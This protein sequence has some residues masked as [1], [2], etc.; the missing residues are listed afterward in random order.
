MRE[1]SLYLAR[2]GENRTRYAHANSTN[3]TACVCVRDDDT[4]VEREREP[5]HA[6]GKGIMRESLN[7]HENTAVLTGEETSWKIDCVTKPRPA[8][9]V[10]S[11]GGKIGIHNLRRATD[12][13][14]TS[15]FVV[16]TIQP[17]SA[18]DE[19]KKLF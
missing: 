13:S 16:Q 19:K 14:P 15:L 4:R 11:R 10:F 7:P 1:S 12:S 17:I 3:H 5:F 6:Q 8:R 18:R 2:L 9:L